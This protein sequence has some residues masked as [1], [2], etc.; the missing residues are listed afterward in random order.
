MQ[1]ETKFKEEV[2]ADLEALQK[3][4]RRLWFYKTQEVAQRGIPDFVICADG[5][6]VALELKATADD[7]AEPLQIYTLGKITQAG[8]MATLVHPDI[9][10]MVKQKL[11]SHLELG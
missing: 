4:Y 9:W 6:F 2:R 3:K 5:L 8:G 10:P 7:R 1:L 11:V